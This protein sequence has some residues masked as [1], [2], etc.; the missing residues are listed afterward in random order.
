MLEEKN[1]KIGVKYVN[2]QEV[3]AKV[4]ISS[5]SCAELVN[6]TVLLESQ[7]RSVNFHV[8][9]PLS[10]SQDHSKTSA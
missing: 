3:F 2:I 8:P 9:V 4:T 1:K 7:D 6:A 5:E 10:E